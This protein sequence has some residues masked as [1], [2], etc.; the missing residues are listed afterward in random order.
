M[1]LQYLDYVL[2]EEPLIIWVTPSKPQTSTY[3]P[4]I[5]TQGKNEFSHYNLP[6]KEGYY[7]A[8]QGVGVGGG[9][10]G[11]IPKGGLKTG[12]VQLTYQVIYKCKLWAIPPARRY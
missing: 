5:D 2:A 4:I 6:S 1:L 3:H 9:S 10:I 7:R 12:R 8:K 11:I